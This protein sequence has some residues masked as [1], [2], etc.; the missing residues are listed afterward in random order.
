MRVPVK[1]W[2]GRHDRFVP[3]QHGQWLAEHVPGA[4]AE[5]SETDGHLTFLVDKVGE[6]HDWLLAHF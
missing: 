5:L 4:E 2:H 6:I 1:I 3:F